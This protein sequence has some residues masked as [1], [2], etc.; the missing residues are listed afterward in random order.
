MKFVVM[1]VTFVSLIGSSLE[2]RIEKKLK[3]EEPA[4]EDDPNKWFEY[5]Y[6]C[7]KG[8]NQ[9]CKVETAEHLAICKEHCGEKGCNHFCMEPRDNW[10]SI[11]CEVSGTVDPAKPDTELCK[12][13]KGSQAECRSYFSRV[14]GRDV[15][16][17]MIPSIERADEQKRLDNIIKE[18]VEKERQKRKEEF[19]QKIELK[20]KQAERKLIEAKANEK[21]SQNK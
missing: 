10:F 15:F 5:K 20:K 14:A 21:K 13:Q 11:N 12:K 7:T 1:I 4:K 19:N 9:S 16:A 6:N 8:D 2:K 17:C 18:K 3:S